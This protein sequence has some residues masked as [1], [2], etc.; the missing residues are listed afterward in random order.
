MPY[1]ALVDL[2]HTAEQS[3]EAMGQLSKA[4]ALRNLQTVLGQ[5][6]KISQELQRKMAAQL[7][8]QLRLNHYAREFWLT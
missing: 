5:E 2:L 8:T 1:D 7:R 4:I 6:S 3:C